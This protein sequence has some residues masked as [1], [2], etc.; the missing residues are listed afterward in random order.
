MTLA[1]GV[2]GLV[3]FALA[4]SSFD[5]QYQLLGTGWNWAVAG[6]L[7]TVLVLMSSLAWVVTPA[8]LGAINACL[9]GSCLLGLLTLVPNLQ[10]GIVLTPSD[11]RLWLVN[12]STIGASAGAVAWRDWIAWGYLGCAVALIAVDQAAAS[13]FVSWGYPLREAGFQL[14][15]GAVFVALAQATR[16]A[17]QALDAAEN[18][19][20]TEARR[21]AGANARSRE[22]ARVNALVHD[23]VLVALLAAGRGEQGTLTRREA[24]RALDQLDTP[25]EGTDSAF[26]SGIEC[27]W[28]LQAITTELAPTATF[29]SELRTPVP[30]PVHVAMAVEEAAAEALKNS[31]NHAEPER[32]TVSRAVHFIADQSGIEATILDDGIGFEP[33][34][35]PSSR[36]GIAVSILGRMNSEPGGLAI[37]VSER[38]IGTRVTLRWRAG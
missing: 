1:L 24:Q 27:A 9:A 16:R 31:V 15:F 17:G 10:H 7:L 26:R 34:V 36:L 32:G 38:G 3:F 2:G 33:S 22:R 21:F 8:T 35:V 28:A 20:V 30:V 29:S 18:A 12:L 19:A 5:N 37:V 11:S 25:S 6:A 4:A 14:F 23:T 13:G